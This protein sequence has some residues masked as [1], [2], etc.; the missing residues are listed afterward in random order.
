MIAEVNSS[1][2]AIPLGESPAIRIE[3]NSSNLA[4][5]LSEWRVICSN[6]EG[7][8]MW[9]HERGGSSVYNVGHGR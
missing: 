3:W 6:L 7:F 8:K 4:R 5:A 1:V 2:S 9:E